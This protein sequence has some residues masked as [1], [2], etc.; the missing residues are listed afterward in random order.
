MKLTLRDLFWLVALA[1][2][3][4]AWWMDRGRIRVRE[5]ELQSLIERN[6][7]MGEQISADLHL[8]ELRLQQLQEVAPNP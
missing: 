4:C 1:A 3:G 6:E 2:L 7:K 8:V 5:Q